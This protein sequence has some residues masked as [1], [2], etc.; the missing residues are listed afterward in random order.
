MRSVVLALTLGVGGLSV[1]LDADSATAKSPGVAAAGAQ[2]PKLEEWP[3]LAKDARGR[4]RKELARLRKARTPEM[5]AEAHEALVEIGA[6]AAPGLLTALG[7][8]KDPAARKRLV[9]TLDAIAGAAHTRLL[10]PYFSDESEAL[11]LWSL[12]CA[13]RFPDPGT[14]PAAEAAWAALD[15]EKRRTPPSD[16]ERLSSALAVTA[17]GST[18]ALDE[19]VARAGDGWGELAPRASVALVGAKG[20]AATDHLVPIV[21][22]GERFRALGALRLVG[23]CGTQN[24]GL[25][26]ALKNRLNEDDNTL[27]IAAINALRGVMDGDPPLEKLSVFDSIEEA[28]KWKERLR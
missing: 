7:K 2:D 3:E 22:T 8:E 26:I 21:K 16:E 28:K 20:E 13:S 17:S 14:R 6:G 27:R 12:A 1:P 10:V 15:D 18:A 5:G 23:Y 4:A 11:R 9:T 25:V 24:T 19:L